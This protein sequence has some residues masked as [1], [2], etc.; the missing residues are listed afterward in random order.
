[1]GGRIPRPSHLPHPHPPQLPSFGAKGGLATR[2]VR[3]DS[4]EDAFGDVGGMEAVVP[5]SFAT[6]GDAEMI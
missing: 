3:S 5:H 6:D 1:M 4:S 2:E